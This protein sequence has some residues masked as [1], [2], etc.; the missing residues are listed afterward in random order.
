MHYSQLYSL[1]TS[2][3][4][5]HG[6][7]MLHGAKKNVVNCYLSNKISQ[8]L[9]YKRL[10]KVHFLRTSLAVAYEMYAKEQMKLGFRVLSQSLVYRYLKGRFRI[11]KKIPFKDTQCADC[12]NSSLLVDT[13]I[14]AKVRG[15]RRRNTEN[16]LNSFCPLSDKDKSPSADKDNTISRKL[17]W[18]DNSEVITDHNCDCIFRNCKRC[19]A[20][21]MLQESII[22]QNPDIDWAKQVTWHQWQ[23]VLLDNGENNTKKK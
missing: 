11:R 5:P 21:S 16:V 22:K 19:G 15:I 4:K 10:K 2:K 3:R 1:L 6:R 12:V 23:Y 9:P 13:L 7:A 17:V 8:Q 14:V 20:I 18:H